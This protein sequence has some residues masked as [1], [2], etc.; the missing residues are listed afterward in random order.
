MGISY[1]REQVYQSLSLY[2][3]THTHT[4]TQQEP[5]AEASTVL[6]STKMQDH[7]A[8]GLPPQP[9]STPLNSSSSS[10][11]TSPESARHTCTSQVPGDLEVLKALRAWRQ[12]RRK[13]EERER[14]RSL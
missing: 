8:R 7:G 6:S 5:A 1:I 4:H 9:L 3:H 2:M 10:P 14:E 13:R 11:D 12:R